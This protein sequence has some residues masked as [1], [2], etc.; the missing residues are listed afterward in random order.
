MS[1]QLTHIC[2]H[3]GK[4]HLVYPSELKRGRGIYCSKDCAKSYSHSPAYIVICK[5]CNNVFYSR[6]G[7]VFCSLQCKE[8]YIKKEKTNSIY[9]TQ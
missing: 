1:K 7:R 9:K 3:C 5:E 8:A 4:E 6:I 2:E